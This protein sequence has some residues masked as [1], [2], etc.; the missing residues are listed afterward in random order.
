MG[1]GKLKGLLG[2]AEKYQRSSGVSITPISGLKMGEVACEE[3]L[4]GP[5]A[6]DVAKDCDIV[7]R[8]RWV[9]PSINS[10]A[11]KYLNVFDNPGTL[12]GHAA[13]ASSGV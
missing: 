11:L 4:T 13:A 2:P 3:G 1:I 7:W 5:S 6:K 12:A 10:S 8:F 9:V